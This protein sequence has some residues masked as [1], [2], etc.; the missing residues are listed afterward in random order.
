MEEKDRVSSISHSRS[1]EEMAE[2]WDTHDATDFEDQTYEVDE[3]AM[4]DSYDRSEWRSIPSLADEVQRYRAYAA[5]Q[6][7]AA[8]E[9]QVMLSPEDL[10]GIQEKARQ[11]GVSYQELIASIVHKFVAGQ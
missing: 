6:I 5:V 1:L 11:V 2:F 9:V 8:E 4:L 7:G 10:A 3:Q